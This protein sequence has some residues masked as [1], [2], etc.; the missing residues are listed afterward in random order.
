[1]GF[2]SQTSTFFKFILSYELPWVAEVFLAMFYEDELCED[3][4]GKIGYSED[5]KLETAHEKPLAP[6]VLMNIKKLES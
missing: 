3:M 6:R 5:S 2:R 1:M 4:I